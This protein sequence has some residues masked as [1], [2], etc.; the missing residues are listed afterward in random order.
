MVSKNN[1]SLFIIYNNKKRFLSTKSANFIIMI[2]E[3]SCD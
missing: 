3:G 2:S 1:V